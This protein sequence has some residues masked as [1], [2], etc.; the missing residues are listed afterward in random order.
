MPQVNV[1]YPRI[2]RIS[3]HSKASD[4]D[5]DSCVWA[6]F[7]FDTNDYSLKIMSDCGNY[8][9]AWTPTPKTE[10]FLALCRRLEPEYLLS[11]LS[12]ETELNIKATVKNVIEYIYLNIGYCPDLEDGWEETLEDELYQRETAT[13][14]ADYIVRFANECNI[15]LDCYDSWQCIE[16]DY[17]A[18]ARRIVQIFEEH[19]KP[20]IPKE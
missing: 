20:K 17:P 16:K 6:D 9:Y 8:A 4:P 10:S 7:D 1:Y 18:G 13:E 19:I 2:I 3:F 11:K 15:D 12:S 5:C 14:I